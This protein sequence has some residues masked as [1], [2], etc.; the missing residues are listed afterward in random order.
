MLILMFLLTIAATLGVVYV[1]TVIWGVLFASALPSVVG[2]LVGGLSALP[3][4]EGL[5][6]LRNKPP[7]E[8]SRSVAKR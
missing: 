6:R 7:P 1:A 5:R 3:I 8:A 2:G 4:W